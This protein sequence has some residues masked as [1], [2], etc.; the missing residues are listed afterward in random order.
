MVASQTRNSNSRLSLKPFWE[1]IFCSDGAILFE[2]FHH[3]YEYYY[4]YYYYCYYYHYDAVK[5][6]A[7]SMNLIQSFVLQSVETLRTQSQLV[8]GEIQVNKKHVRSLNGC[9]T[10]CSL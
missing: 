5:I 2:G 1:L 3:Y 7:S 6:I 10:H 8:T 4:Y 9:P